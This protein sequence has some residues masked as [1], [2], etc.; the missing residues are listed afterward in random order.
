MV[1]FKR[2]TKY[3][4]SLTAR[5]LEGFPRLHIICR[6]MVSMLVFLKGDLPWRGCETRSHRTMEGRVQYK[7][8]IWAVVN[9]PYTFTELSWRDIVRKRFRIAEGEDRRLLLIRRRIKV[10]VDDEFRKRCW[11]DICQ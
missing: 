3:R 8:K 5:L 4:S 6:K 11:S 1:P 10:T 7:G 2:S 9:S